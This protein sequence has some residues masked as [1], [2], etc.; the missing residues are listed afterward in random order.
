MGGKSPKQ[1]LERII[2]HKFFVNRYILGIF[3]AHDKQ[4][5]QRGLHHG[6]NNDRPGR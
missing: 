5:A 4:S 6:E 1:R 3:G 2:D